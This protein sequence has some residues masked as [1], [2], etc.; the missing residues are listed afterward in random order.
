MKAWKY[1]SNINKHYLEV[2]ESGELTKTYRQSDEWTEEKS[3]KDM[4]AK[5]KLNAGPSGVM[6]DDEDAE[7]ECPEEKQDRLGC[8]KLH[9]GVCHKILTSKQSKFQKPT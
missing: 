9:D 8:L 6:S 4:P 1:D 2:D 7:P 3:C 5:R